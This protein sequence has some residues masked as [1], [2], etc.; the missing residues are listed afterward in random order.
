VPVKAPDITI[1][2]IMKADGIS[3]KATAKGY[4]GSNQMGWDEFIFSKAD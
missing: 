1:N 2:I 3:Y 4:E